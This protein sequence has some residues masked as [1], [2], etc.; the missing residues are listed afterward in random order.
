MEKGHKKNIRRITSEYMDRQVLLHEQ[1]LRRRKGL[2]RRLT[3]FGLLVIIL[4][5]FTGITMYNQHSL[6]EDLNEEKARLESKLE[7]L[8]EEE[9]DL[10]EEIQLL[11][12]P[13][14]IAEI[15]RRDFFLTKPGETLFQLPRSTTTSD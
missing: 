14:Y 4:V 5:A 15:A 9:K 12:D 8:Q 10:S 11:H 1:K 2:M 7:V 6:L 13:D 3:V